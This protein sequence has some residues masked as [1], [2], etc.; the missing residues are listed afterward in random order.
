MSTNLIPVSA[1]RQPHSTPEIHEALKTLRASD[2]R[3]E[4]DYFP[5]GR[6][7]RAGGREGRML[8]LP[9]QHDPAAFDPRAAAPRTPRV[10]FTVG[11]V[12]ST[13]GAREALAMSGEAERKFTYRHSTGDFGEAP[14]DERAENLRSA[15]TQRGTILSMFRTKLG[16]RVWI[17]TNEVRD[18]TTVF[19]PAEVGEVVFTEAEAPEGFGLA[20]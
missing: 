16:E 13:P 20:A 1:T 3:L 7:E 10:S 12:T 8:T 2:F 17:T 18:R 9:R 6:A 4:A 19:L 11:R 14:P 15:R 5:C